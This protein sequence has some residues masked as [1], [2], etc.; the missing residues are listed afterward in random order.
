MRPYVPRPTDRKKKRAQVPV[1]TRPTGKK[2]RAVPGITNGAAK[3]TAEVA[4]AAAVGSAFEG[5]FSSAF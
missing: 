2:A 1:T 5:A 3:K 4:A